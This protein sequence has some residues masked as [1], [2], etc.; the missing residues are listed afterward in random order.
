MYRRLLNINVVM[1]RKVIPNTQFQR[2]CCVFFVAL[3]AV[4]RT[5]NQLLQNKKVIS[6]VIVYHIYTNTIKCYQ[7]LFHPEHQEGHCHS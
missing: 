5:Q 4:R 6:V 7:V 2:S 1:R 3:S